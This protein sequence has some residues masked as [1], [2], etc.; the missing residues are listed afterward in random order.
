MFK[1]NQDK[2][3]TKPTEWKVIEELLIAI[4]MDAIFEGNRAWATG[5]SNDFEVEFQAWSGA[6]EVGLVT[7]WKNEHA[8]GFSWVL[9]EPIA[10]AAMWRFFDLE[11]L[12]TP[13]GSPDQPLYLRRK[14]SGLPFFLSE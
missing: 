8:Q 5:H 9:E 6:L 4:Y 14:T 12:S 10:Q 13:P 7:L 3:K 2:Y 1:R 11:G